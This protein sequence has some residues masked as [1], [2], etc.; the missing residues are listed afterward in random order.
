MGRGS[1]RA[2]GH[3]A[4]GETLTKQ[5]S[6]H[7]DSQRPLNE[8]EMRLIQTLRQMGALNEATSQPSEKIERRASLKH[9]PLMHALREL[10]RKGQ[11]VRIVGRKDVLFHVR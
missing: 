6:Q 8:T 9:G 1:R 10:E 11:V 4:G 5:N 7:A 2:G 3:R